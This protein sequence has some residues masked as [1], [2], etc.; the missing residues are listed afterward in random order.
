[1]ALLELENTNLRKQNK[2]LYKQNSDFRELIQEY[3]AC[4]EKAND[5]MGRIEAAR[6][7]I[8]RI[9][10]DVTVEVKTYEMAKASV[11]RAE[12][13]ATREWKKFVNENASMGIEVEEV[14]RDIITENAMEITVA[15]PYQDGGNMI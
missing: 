7:A 4:N 3:K 5:C 14:V 10:Q 15:Y 9:T 1:M 13:V 6:D 11:R 12:R 8:G 2:V